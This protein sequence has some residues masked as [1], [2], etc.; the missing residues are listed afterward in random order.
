RL[1]TGGNRTVLARQHTL[2]ESL[3]WSFDLLDDDERAVV[4]RLSICPG[5]FDLDAAEAIAADGDDIDVAS[6]LDTLG[7]LV[8]KSLVE[9]DD[10]S[11]QYRMLSTV[12][13]YAFQRLRDAGAVDATRR[14]HAE[15]W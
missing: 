1:L 14:R 3:R 2:A 15:Y 10:T 7:R 9:L 11:G 6:V 5:W 4:A 12:R 8:D 13:Q